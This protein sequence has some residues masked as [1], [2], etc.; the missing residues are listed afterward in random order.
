MGAVAAQVAVIILYCVWVFAVL[1]AV[2]PGQLA[3]YGGTALEPLAAA[4]GPAVRWLGTVFTILAIGMAAIHTSLALFNSVREQLPENENRRDRSAGWTRKSRFLWCILPI[5]VIFAT[6]ES[7]LMTGNE[8]FAAVMNFG[9]LIGASIF[10]GVFPALL[11]AASRR[12]GDMLPAAV[13]RLVGHPLVLGAVYTL[14]LAAIFAH[15]LVIWQEV[16]Q[17]LAA[18]ACGSI[19]VMITVAAWRQ[20]AFRGRTV[21]QLREDSADECAR[22]EVLARGRPAAVRVVATSRGRDESY[23]AASGTLPDVTSMRRVSFEFPPMPE[24]EIKVWLYEVV[25]EGDA[26]GLPARITVDTG[27]GTEVAVC[28]CDASAEPLLVPLSGT[29]CCVAVEFDV[30]PK[31]TDVIRT[32][33]GI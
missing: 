16:L 17:R 1:C 24:Q 2:P 22:F 21:V 6:A 7:L 4:I 3:T 8:S 11:L 32:G 23:Y 33:R 30:P 10:A 29:A 20:G 15:G 13:N 19:V 18:V 25:P 28:D 12:K 14:F 9:G 31:R 26:I 27:D 5:L